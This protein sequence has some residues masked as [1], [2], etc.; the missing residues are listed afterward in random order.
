[1]TR[2]FRVA[3]AVLVLGTPA[4]RRLPTAAN[5]PPSADFDF[6]PVAP[7]YAGQTKVTFN[8]APSKDTDGSIV[9]YLWDFGDGTPQQNLGV[10]TVH[11]FPVVGTCILATY[12][13]RLTVVD[14]QNAQTS[15]DHTV[16]VTDLPLPNS[17]ICTASPAPTH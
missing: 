11:V 15:V 14:N 9:A 1:M 16:T 6:N 3:A 17:P 13:V 8:A 5:V 7:I 12:S 10:T 2:L 4:C